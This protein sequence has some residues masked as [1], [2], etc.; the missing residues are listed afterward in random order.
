MRHRLLRS[1]FEVVRIKTDQKFPLDGSCVA[2]CRLLIELKNS[3]I[4]FDNIGQ[5]ISIALRNAIPVIGVY[6]FD[7][8]IG[9]YLY[10]IVAE[11][12]VIAL[13]API[14]QFW[15]S[16]G[17][18]LSDRISNA[19]LLGGTTIASYFLPCLFLFAIA[20]GLIPGSNGSNSLD[21]SEFYQPIVANPIEFLVLMISVI[22]DQIIWRRENRRAATSG[23]MEFIHSVIFSWGSLLLI[24]TFASRFRGDTD[25]G[26]F[27]TA[28]LWYCVSVML[29][30]EML[31]T[32]G[33]ERLNRILKKIF[34]L[35]S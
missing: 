11:M 12:V 10:Y 14:R 5:L 19:V 3:R 8:S 6:F 31:I 25:P 17:M 18:P 30:F 7:W 34:P 4:T 9:V 21:V 29:A 1:S 32:F 13:A 27:A 28:M 26:V 15:L 24:I 2:H 16:D 35:L 23:F 22:W 20:L 33:K